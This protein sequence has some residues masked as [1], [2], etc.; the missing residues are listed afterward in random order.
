MLQIT[1]FNCTYISCN[2]LLKQTVDESV[3]LGAK[4]CQWSRPNLLLDLVKQSTKSGVGLSWL[5]GVLE[6][7]PDSVKS[8]PWRPL[9]NM[10]IEYAT[11]SL[12][13]VPPFQ[14]NAPKP[15]EIGSL[16][17]SREAIEANSQD[18]L[19]EAI[20]RALS[21][22]II[23][24][25][26]VCSD[27]E[28][29][30]SNSIIA[31]KIVKFFLN[32]I[33]EENNGQVGENHV[34]AS[35]ALAVVFFDAV[36]L[37]ET[38][39]STR[40][41]DYINHS[42]VENRDCT[43]TQEFT[44]LSDD[45]LRLMH[46]DLGVSLLAWFPSLTQLSVLNQLQHKVL[47][48]M[49]HVLE[50]KMTEL[51][52]IHRIHK[53]A[54]YSDDELM[55]LYISMG[56]HFLWYF[57]SR[58]QLFCEH[59]KVLDAIIQLSNVL[60]KAI[61]LVHS[62]IL[63]RLQQEST[64]I[65]SVHALFQKLYSNDHLNL[66]YLDQNTA[67]L[68][69]PNINRVAL[70]ALTVLLA[71]AAMKGKFVECSIT[72]TM[73]DGYLSKE[74]KLQEDASEES[75]EESDNTEE[76]NDS[77]EEKDDHQLYEPLEFSDCKK[78]MTLHIDLQAAQ[79][80]ITS[81]GI[82]NSVCI[83]DEVEEIIT[84]EIPSQ[85]VST[86]VSILSMP[87]FHSS[88]TKAM[89]LT[90]NILCHEKKSAY[91]DTHLAFTPTWTQLLCFFRNNNHTL[92]HA[93]LS[94]AGIHHICKSL[95]MSGISLEA[96]H[97]MLVRLD[98][99]QTEDWIQL[100]TIGTK[101][102]S[103]RRN[104][105]NA[106]NDEFESLEMEDISAI[107]QPLPRSGVIYLRR[108][109]FAIEQ[110]RKKLCENGFQTQNAGEKASTCLRHTLQQ[111][112][113][114]MKDAR[115]NVASTEPNF[116]RKSPTI[117]QSDE[118]M[119]SVDSN[120]NK[121][122]QKDEA[123]VDSPFLF[124]KL[125]NFHK[126]HQPDHSKPEFNPIE[127]AVSMT[128]RAIIPNLCSVINQLPKQEANTITVPNQITSSLK[129][130]LCR[131]IKFADWWTISALLISLNGSNINNQHLA[132]LLS[133]ALFRSTFFGDTNTRIQFPQI[134]IVDNS[135]RVLLM[136]NKSSSRAQVPLISP[137]M[138]YKITANSSGWNK[139]LCT[140]PILSET[141]AMERAN[142]VQTLCYSLSTF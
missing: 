15:F 129:S 43:C 10:L 75:G 55:A 91:A 45:F 100:A 74:N 1:I 72:D 104:S 33:S 69:P 81:I 61:T 42:Q 38:K 132:N 19:V 34:A 41:K 46:D 67:T 63:Q 101:T 123:M 106:N 138:F 114:S 5:T 105:A 134:T 77:S 48:V 96:R 137:T 89:I 110:N 136:L 25:K 103:S 2:C 65:E 57:V 8:L 120:F 98:R 12:R 85:I 18:D 7:D 83:I 4:F 50:T 3:Q 20:M 26:V 90:L 125:P 84:I 37:K 6:R 14:C 88:Q 36:R 92:V 9:C 130:L 135:L 116:V 80:V 21:E 142:Q 82:S 131:I 124:D 39:L 126:I 13:S 121:G 58:D 86:I 76:G 118:L 59:A 73:K 62:Q 128:K 95:S 35:R 60:C 111:I 30:R 108:F 44:R 107:Q 23:R 11:S 94:N 87:L 113:D 119:H 71:K 53:S 47:H 141:V 51:K 17:N 133:E 68:H 28:I 31:I 32:H 112:Y 22:M 64:V 70:F 54:T 16:P 27:P 97:A 78:N 99:T 122:E 52:S 49:T 79:A 115:T 140:S 40:E 102:Q 109:L 127:I 24:H 56:I 93:A 139:E 29:S 117:L 66:V